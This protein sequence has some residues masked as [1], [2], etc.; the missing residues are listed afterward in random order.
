MIHMQVMMLFIMHVSLY[1]CVYMVYLI[2]M[3][4]INV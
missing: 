4:L 3:Q 2:S 1:R